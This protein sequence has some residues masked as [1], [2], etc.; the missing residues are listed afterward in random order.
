MPRKYLQS[1][2]QSAL[3][4]L[5]LALQVDSLGPANIICVDDLHDVGTAEALFLHLLCSPDAGQLDEDAFLGQSEKRRLRGGAML[6]YFLIWPPHPLQQ[7]AL[8]RTV[9]DL[10]NPFLVP[11]GLLCEGIP[12]RVENKHQPPGSKCPGMGG[13]LSINQT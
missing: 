10:N 12:A 2:P 9:R 13:V 11:N 8:G 6:L 3:H 4:R 5:H 1:P 7:V